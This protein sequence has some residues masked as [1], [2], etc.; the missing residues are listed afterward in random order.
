MLAALYAFHSNDKPRGVLAM[1]CLL[2]VLNCLSSFPNLLHASVRQL[3][4]L[5]HGAGRTG[6]LAMVRLGVQVFYGFLSLFI[7][8]ALPFLSSLAGLLGV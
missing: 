6:L 2:V 7:S 5:L 8:V 4:G 1:T 3:R